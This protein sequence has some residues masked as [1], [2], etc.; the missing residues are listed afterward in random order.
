MRQHV[1]N[2][3]PFCRACELAGFNRAS[4]RADHIVP[5]SQGGSNERSNFQGLCIPCHDLK[6]AEEARVGRG[7][8]PRP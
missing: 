4:Q 6:T 1:L 3:E 2:E 5:L 8:E 7:A